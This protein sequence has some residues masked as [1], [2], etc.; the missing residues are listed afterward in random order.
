MESIVAKAQPFQRVEDTKEEARGMFQ[1]NRFKANHSLCLC[2]PLPVA[3]ECLACGLLPSKKWWRI[4]SKMEST[5]AEAQPFLRVEVTK[6][7]AFEI[8]RRSRVPLCFPLAVAV[9]WRGVQT[10]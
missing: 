2:M 9:Q 4:A 8:F 1:D 3:F 10:D 5:V 7:E 6:E